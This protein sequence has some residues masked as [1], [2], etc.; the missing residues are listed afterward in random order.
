MTFYNQHITLNGMS[1][2]VVWAIEPDDLYGVLCDDDLIY[3]ISGDIIRLYGTV[4]STKG[5]T[6]CQ[7]VTQ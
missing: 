7:N 5:A 1:G 2:L 6:K 3:T 4:I